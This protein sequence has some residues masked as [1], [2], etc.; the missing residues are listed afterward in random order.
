MF[1]HMP[2]LL[3]SHAFIPKTSL[4]MGPLSLALVG[5]ITVVFALKWLIMPI[6]L[7]AYGDGKTM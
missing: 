2:M 3:V 5:A 6:L 7:N 1:T 4:K